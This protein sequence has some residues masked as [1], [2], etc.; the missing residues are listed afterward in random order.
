[1]QAQK[2][3]RLSD[4]KFDALCV[5]YNYGLG[6]CENFPTCKT[7]NVLQV[8]KTRRAEKERKNALRVCVRQET[9]DYVKTMLSEV[10]FSYP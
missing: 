6:K 5:R 4:R 3:V 10:N 8:Q 9:T 1:M 7:S 2:S